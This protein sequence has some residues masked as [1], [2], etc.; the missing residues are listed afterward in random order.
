MA[1]VL[2]ASANMRISNL[3]S[4]EGVMAA[5]TKSVN[6]FMTQTSLMY[7]DEIK[8][9]ET[10]NATVPAVLAQYQTGRV[11]ALSAAQS[12]VDQANVTAQNYNKT[13]QN[14][15][16]DTNAAITQ[17]NYQ[18]GNM[19]LSIPAQIADI[20]KAILSAVESVETSQDAV[21]KSLITATQDAKS[22]VV[23]KLK[24][25]RTQKKKTKY[26]LDVEKIALPTQAPLIEVKI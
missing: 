26:S 22:T 14:L 12:L 18:L 9:L 16:T 4:V 11:L 8:K 25:F 23:T 3:K 17:A 20:K 7:N 10:F 15:I 5:F 1:D 19:T 24:N 2:S 6:D 21:A 13:E